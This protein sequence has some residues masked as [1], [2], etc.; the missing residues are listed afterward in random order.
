MAKS[1]IISGAAK[2]D[3]ADIKTYTLLQHGREAYVDYETLLQA[4]FQDLMDETVPALLKSRPEIGPDMFSYHIR[5]SKRRADNKVRKPRHFILF[6][7]VGDDTL[8]VSRVLHD[9]R[10]LARHFEG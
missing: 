4:A 5:H 3:L 9:S 7:D 2:A 6:K 8:L 10:E 1:L